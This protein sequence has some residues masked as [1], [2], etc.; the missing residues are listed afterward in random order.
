MSPR[1]TKEAAGDAPATELGSGRRLSPWLHRRIRALSR[2]NWRV[3]R[4]AG[5]KGT[6]LLFA[7]TGI[8]G[9]VSADRVDETLTWI[10]SA[11]GLAIDSVRITGQTETSEIAVLN[12][13]ELAPEASLAT[14]D[15]AAARE[16]V[17]TLPWV[18]NATLRKIYPATLKITINERKP[19]VLW[20]RDQ[21]VSV[22]DESGRVI[23]DASDTHYQDLIRVVGQGADKRAGEAIALAGAASAIRDRLRAAVLISE[24]R[25]NLVLDNG[26]TLM[27]PQDK[28]EAALQVIAAL[29]AKDGLL[30]KDIVSVDLRLADRMFVRLTPEAAA[31]RTAEIKEREK[32]AK[33]KGAST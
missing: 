25:W 2:I 23:G 4:H 16:R 12:R 13:L 14:F 9:V 7:A 3:P 33:R 20:Q 22:I 28:P 6:F 17:E 19:Y 5:L 11:S 29:D 32:L 27:L 18:E 26:V 1:S 31:R 30:S 8:A 10:S 24:R 15:L 21:T